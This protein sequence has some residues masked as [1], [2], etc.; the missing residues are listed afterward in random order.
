MAARKTKNT[1]KRSLKS[2]QATKDETATAYVWASSYGS[3]EA[4]TAAKRLR[5]AR[6][7]TSVAG[8]ASCR[9]IHNDAGEVVDEASKVAEVFRTH[10]K[11]LATPAMVAS[12]DA[13]HHAYVERD[14]SEWQT[15]GKNV[16]QDEY[17]GAFTESEM[18]AA[19][20]KLPMH[21]L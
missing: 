2:K 5:N 19:A 17:D 13:E 9:G 20:D 6:A 11:T 8:A 16:L 10:Y 18:E 12:Y 3:K 7:G 14:V 4:W 15:V 1:L 21:N